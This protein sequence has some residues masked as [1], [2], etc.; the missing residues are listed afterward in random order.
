MKE[1]IKP[2]IEI[3]E[4]STE[5][6]VTVSFVGN[7]GLLEDIADGRNDGMVTSVMS[8]TEIFSTTP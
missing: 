5:N 6:I 3:A 4:F 2:V 1:Y 7:G 8:Y